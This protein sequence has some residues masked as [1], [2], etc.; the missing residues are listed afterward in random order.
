MAAA[1]QEAE[2]VAALRGLTVRSF[3]TR[4]DLF[5]WIPRL[6]EVAGKALASAYR[7]YPASEA[8]LVEYADDFIAG[9]DPRL[10][11]VLMKDDQPVGFLLARRDLSAALQKAAG[12]LFPLGWLS[13][14]LNSR[15]ARQ[16]DVVCLALL[17]EYA[18]SACRLL[19]GNALASALKTARIEGLHVLQVNEADG[20]LAAELEGLGVQWVQ[21][22][23]IYRM[24]NEE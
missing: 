14:W 11:K 1:L 5:L 21:R 13:L 3:R 10:V 17:P 6:G 15:G 24:K 7:H 18:S 23:C 20:E 16:A 2:K 19:L 12:R 4:S 8:E 22:H 9:A